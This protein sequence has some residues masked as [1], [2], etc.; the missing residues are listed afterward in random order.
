MQSVQNIVVAGGLALL[1]YAL[2]QL[3]FHPLSRFPVAAPIAALTD[4]WTAK[5]VRY[6]PLGHDSY[7][8]HCPQTYHK[9]QHL[10]LRRLHDQHGEFV[11]I[12]PDHVSTT[13]GS[14]IAMLYMK[15]SGVLKGRF[16][17]GFTAILPNLFG[18]RDGA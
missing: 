3:F 10:T 15:G 7:T 17:D 6:A 9:R 12:G 14:A 11:R 16:Y 8:L 1:A 5:E 2:R 18:T 13:N 4:F